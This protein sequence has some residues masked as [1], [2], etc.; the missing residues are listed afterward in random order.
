MIA[1]Q[2]YLAV[3][4]G[5]PDE[6][7]KVRSGMREFLSG[8]PKPDDAVLIVSELAANAILHSASQGGMFTVRAER[9]GTWVRLEV[10][11]AGG[12]WIPHPADGRPHGLDLVSCLARTW[13]IDSLPTGRTV[14]A[15]VE[16]R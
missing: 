11:D 2:Q 7:A 16:V 14:W 3:F 8:Y 1:T 15:A 4:H 6:V 5:S 10:E 12:P 13:G 9:H